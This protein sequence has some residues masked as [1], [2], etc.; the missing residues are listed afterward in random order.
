MNTTSSTPA[1]SSPSSPSSDHLQ[2][3]PPPPGPLQISYSTFRALVKQVSKERFASL[4]KDLSNIS[5]RDWRRLETLQI[6]QR[7]EAEREHYSKQLEATLRACEKA[8]LE[9][10][11]RS[12]QQFQQLVRSIHERTCHDPQRCPL[13]S[14]LQNYLQSLSLENW[15]YLSNHFVDHSVWNPKKL[16]WASL[17]TES[18][19]RALDFCQK[20]DRV[21]Q[22]NIGEI[23]Y[24]T[25]IIIERTQWDS[26]KDTVAHLPNS[27]LHI[28]LSIL[29]A[30]L[31][32]LTFDNFT[33]I[34]RSETSVLPMPKTFIGWITRVSQDVKAEEAMRRSPRPSIEKIRQANQ[35]IVANSNRIGNLCRTVL[36]N[37]WIEIWQASTREVHIAQDYNCFRSAVQ[38]IPIVEGNDGPRLLREALSQ[39]TWEDVNEVYN[40]RRAEFVNLVQLINAV[41]KSVEELRTA[42]A[43]RGVSTETLSSLDATIARRLERVDG[44]CTLIFGSHRW[45]SI[46]KTLS[47]SDPAMPPSSPSSLEHSRLAFRPTRRTLTH[48]TL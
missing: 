44:L 20:P 47:S 45:V 2:M 3:L 15:I 46:Y 13:N 12:F 17:L 1:H 31:A 19:E 5:E 8:L 10:R 39:I 30:A 23:V 25:K 41:A 32:K 16:D 36:N 43:R 9:R 11:K 6:T 27:R 28:A 29:K 34:C 26:F 4:G 33:Q 21:K 40:S 48:L 38:S 37:R 24:Q 35:M 7:V 18:L 42:T 22:S 14:N